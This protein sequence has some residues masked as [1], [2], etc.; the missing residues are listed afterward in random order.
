MNEKI[1]S[2]SHPTYWTDY[3]YTPLQY[4]PL[5]LNISTDV[6][7]V[8]GGMA[9]ISTAYSLLLS[10]KRVAL[11]EDGYIGSGETGRTSAHLASALDDG[12]V[13]LERLFGQEKTKLILQSHQEA[14]SFIE[15]AVQREKI[16]CEFNYVNGYLFLHPSDRDTLLKDEKEAAERAG[17]K[18]HQLDHTPGLN[19]PTIPSL[20]FEEQAQFN[21]LKYIQGLCEAIVKMGGLIY[22]STHAKEINS[23]GIVTNE[24]Y[25]ISAQHVIV[26]TNTPVNNKFAIHLKQY[27]YRTYVIGCRIKKNSVP[28]ALWWDTGDTK[29]DPDT[30]PYHYVRTA[31]LD[32]NYDLLICGGE[33]HPVGLADAEKTPE[34]ERYLLLYQWAKKHFPVEDVIYQWSGQIMEPMD[35]I[36]F[37]GRNPHDE[38]NVYIC[39]G[40]SGNGLT[41]ATVAAMLITDLVNGKENPLEQIYNP[42]RFKLLGAGKK[43]LKEVVGGTVSYMKHR[44]GKEDVEKVRSLGNN[45]SA[46]VTIDKKKYGIYKDL[47]GVLHMVSAEC[48]H[49]GCIVKW[50]PDEKSWDCPCHGSRFTHLGKVLNGPA[51]SPLPYKKIESDDVV[52]DEAAE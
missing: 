40:D 48:T 17:L 22:T 12:F 3:Q 1:T 36:G 8:G 16:D 24:G 21:P 4:P 14:I 43:F 30:P 44:A 15:S 33:D 18:V 5:N 38:D 41:N 10:G 7:I 9:G 46:V 26:A 11:V 45:D 6:V 28:R 23:K 35:A 32:S 37:I 29:K 31:P 2:G 20:M 50:N 52:S 13:N 49:L 27:A 34:K 25:S 39:T 42:S 47:E 19:K 51:N